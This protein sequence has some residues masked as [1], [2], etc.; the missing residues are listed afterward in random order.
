ML[1]L[2]KIFFLLENMYAVLH[3][4]SNPEHVCSASFYWGRNCEDQGDKRNVRNYRDESLISL[5]LL[6]KLFFTQIRLS[7]IF[8]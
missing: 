3:V 5:R 8:C 7:C 4:T 1:F 6:A 2:I